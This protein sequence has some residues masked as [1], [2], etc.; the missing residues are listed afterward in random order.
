[1]RDRLRRQAAARCGQR[2]LRVHVRVIQ[3]AV[4]AQRHDGQPGKDDLRIGKRRLRV[5]QNLVDH[6]LAHR[7]L[8]PVVGVIVGKRQLHALRA[9]RAQAQ[10]GPFLAV[11]KADGAV[12]GVLLRVVAQ[13]HAVVFKHRHQRRAALLARVLNRP[14][15]L[16][17]Q[18]RPDGR[19][20]R[21]AIDDRKDQQRTQRS[22]RRQNP[23][24]VHFF[25][26]SIVLVYSISRK[27]MLPS[28]SAI[29][30]MIPSSAVKRE[31]ANSRIS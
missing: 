25:A 27:A 2:H 13:A 14:D 20:I 28:V 3:L 23:E 5:R 26:S 7:V 4:R 24:P 31:P 10:L 12:E 6:A 19:R 11:V 18:N 30:A 22:D 9:R 1:M 16:D 15:V 29:C 21:R 8:A 17:V